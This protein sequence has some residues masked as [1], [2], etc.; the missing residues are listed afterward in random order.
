MRRQ[1]RKPHWGQVKEGVEEEEEI[2]EGSEEDEE[3]EEEDEPEYE[4]VGRGD[5]ADLDMD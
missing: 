4:G 1:N 3:Q 2:E 5:F